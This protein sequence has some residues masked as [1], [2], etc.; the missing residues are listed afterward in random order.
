MD[1]DVNVKQQLL[2]EFGLVSIEN[3]ILIIMKALVN[4]VI[5]DAREHVHQSE[6]IEFI[7]PPWHCSPE[8][9]IYEIMNWVNKK[10][11][12]LPQHQKLIL[13]STYKM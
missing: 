12:E 9:P 5:Q 8:P 3:I 6:I 13:I 2:S 11:S 4:Y 10:Q 7:G 1:K